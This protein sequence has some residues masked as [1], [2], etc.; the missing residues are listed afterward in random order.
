MATKTAWDKHPLPILSSP[1]GSELPKAVREWRKS[2][3]QATA[4]ATSGQ[5]LMEFIKSFKRPKNSLTA[6]SL[7]ANDSSGA[8]RIDI[9]AEFESTV[10]TRATVVSRA[11]KC[12]APIHAEVWDDVVKDDAKVEAAFDQFL[13]YMNEFNFQMTRATANAAP[14]HHAIA[15]AKYDDDFGNPFGGVAV[16]FLLTS[17]ADKHV[18][19][20]LDSML[21]ELGEYVA[22][23]VKRAVDVG[24]YLERIH[25]Q[26]LDLVKA[27][28][29]L[30]VLHSRILPKVLVKLSDGRHVGSDRLDCAEWQQIGIKAAEWQVLR[31][32]D[33]SKV[34]WDDVYLDL[35]TTYEH[36]VT[37]RTRTYGGDPT[38]PASRHVKFP[39]GVG[40]GAM[41]MDAS[42]D[43]DDE[44][45][46]GFVRHEFK[47][48][49]RYQTQAVRRKATPFATICANALDTTCAKMP[50]DRLAPRLRT[51]ASSSSFVD[52]AASGFCNGCHGRGRLLQ[53]R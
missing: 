8:K 19:K 7:T 14:A 44:I 52:L 23:D 45:A 11:M 1:S 24:A 16:Y 29:N 49:G 47:D 17:T 9:L 31:D 33:A 43:G 40:L 6:I 22:S 21:E 36:I 37:H 4:A 3:A 48:E 50:S 15:E 13:I 5:W 42:G 46:F 20:R 41:G 34:S 2:A 51:V 18:Q 28:E 39:V 30:T 12:K 32:E 53:A 35:V 38:G 26:Y 27:K 10:T 25:I